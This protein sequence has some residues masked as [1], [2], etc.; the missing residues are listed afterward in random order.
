MT[1]Q[2]WMRDVPHEITDDVLWRMEVYRLALFLS[3]LSWHDS[4]KLTQ[5]QRT[6]RLSGQLYA[7]VGSISA[8]IAEG[9]SRQSRKDQARYYEYALGSARESRGWYHKGRHVLGDPVTSHRLPLTTQIIRHLLRIIPA[10]RGPM[11]KEDIRY[12]N[13]TDGSIDSEPSLEHVPTPAPALDATRNPQ[14]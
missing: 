2:E 5:D 12:S 10:H 11:L 4:T 14:Q 8:N 9:Y 6:V 13:A 7:A 1:Y 3:D